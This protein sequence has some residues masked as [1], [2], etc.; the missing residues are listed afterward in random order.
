MN[1]ENEISP[2][3]IILHEVIDLALALGTT[4]ILVHS[5]LLVL[6]LGL[7]LQLIPILTTLLIATEILLATVG[8]GVF[9]VLA[10]LLGA[11]TGSQLRV[12]KLECRLFLLFRAL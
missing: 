7:L 6:A 4:I 9:I 10:I 11:F 8:A 2:I 1:E 3:T 12:G 5:R